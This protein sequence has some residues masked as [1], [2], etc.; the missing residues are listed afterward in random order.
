MNRRAL[1]GCLALLPLAACAGWRRPAAP[2][3]RLGLSAAPVETVGGPAGPVVAIEPFRTAPA[4]RTDRIAVSEGSVGL[5]FLAQTRWAAEPGPLVAD[6][7]RRSLAASGVVGA[8]W[9]APAPVE[10]D[11]TVTGTVDALL[12]DRAGG[13]GV[14][15]ATWTVLGRDGSV[16]AFR[17]G[18]WAEPVADSGI[19]GFSRAVDRALGRLA[20]ELLRSLRE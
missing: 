8:V 17:H 2:V 16:K 12:W 11:L 18:R 20:T 6:A 1:L 7:L 5:R 4:Y 14:L 10:P 15:E 9:P 19:A 13:A 3:L